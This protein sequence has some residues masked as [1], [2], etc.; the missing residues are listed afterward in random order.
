MGRNAAAPL[1]EKKRQEIT[2][3]GRLKEYPDGTC[4]IMVF[5]RP[6]FKE[7]GWEEADGFI[8]EER[9][10]VDGQEFRWIRDRKQEAKAAEA[11]E[12]AEG[13]EAG[14]EA[15]GPS[16]ENLDRAARRAAGRLR[17]L[18]LCND[19]QWF[20]T[21]T[22]DR[23]KVDRY[24]VK[25]I[26]RKLNTWLDNQVRRR[27]LRYVLVPERHKDG[28]LHFHG[29]VND[30]GSFVPSGTWEVPGHKKPIK[31]RSAAEAARWAAQGPQAGFH[32]VFNWEAWPLGFSTAIRLYGD[33]SAATAYICK[34]V[35]KQNEGGK[36]GGRWFYHGGDLKGPRV[37]LLDLGL[38]ELQKTGAKL[39][40]F[41]IPDAGLQGAIWRGE[42][43]KLESEFTKTGL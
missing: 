21:L 1:V 34:Y 18:V 5:S 7:K 20:V 4:E 27:G 19:F 9:L 24:D 33:Y 12:A 3:T 42:I 14:S 36:I 32:E 11:A 41:E 37:E 2:H 28:A 29:F 26:T 39:Y 10:V 16:P 38:P 35:R 23:E 13:E 25:E 22:L 31:P 17:D 15:P 8:Q 43:S 6:V 30:C 40:A